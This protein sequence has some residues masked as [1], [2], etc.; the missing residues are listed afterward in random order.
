MDPSVANGIGICERGEPD[1]HEYLQDRMVMMYD[2]D[3]CLVVSETKPID[4]PISSFTRSIHPKA[5][6]PQ[7]CCRLSTRSRCECNQSSNRSGDSPCARKPND[8]NR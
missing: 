2:D 6:G 1:G 4:P 8:A 7:L 5:A 3:A